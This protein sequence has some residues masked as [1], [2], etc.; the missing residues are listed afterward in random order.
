MRKLEGQRLVP[1]EKKRSKC[2]FFFLK[3]LLNFEQNMTALWKENEI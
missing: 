3:I 2:F 1:L